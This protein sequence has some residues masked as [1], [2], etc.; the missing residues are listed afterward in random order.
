MVSLGKRENVSR[1]SSETKKQFEQGLAS[2]INLQTG[3]RWSLFSTEKQPMQKHRG[4]KLHRAFG[5]LQGRLILTDHPLWG[6]AE[7]NVREERGD[8]ETFPSTSFC[9]DPFCM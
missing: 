5:E 1:K 3:R 4:V 9:C 7:N 6:G 8:E 2:Q